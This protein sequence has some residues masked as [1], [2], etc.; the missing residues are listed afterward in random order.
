MPAVPARSAARLVAAPAAR[1]AAASTNSA[2][3][4]PHTRRVGNNG[5][6][7]PFVVRVCAWGYPQTYPH[8]RVCLAGGGAEWTPSTGG[9]VVNW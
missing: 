1:A 3:T 4:Y 8:L 6:F 5:G 7:P 2:K 9:I